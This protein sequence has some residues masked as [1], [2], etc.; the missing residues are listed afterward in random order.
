MCG[1]GGLGPFLVGEH[2]SLW[3]G[4]TIWIL[5]HGHNN[6]VVVKG[7]IVLWT[8][9]GRNKARKPGYN[10]AG[11]YK[12]RQDKTGDAL[13]SHGVKPTWGFHKVKLRKVETRRHALGF[14]L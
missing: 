11:K 3:I 9:L 12:T 10:Q 2:T 7:I 14:Q 1:C 13:P 5:H 4:D 8:G 6:K